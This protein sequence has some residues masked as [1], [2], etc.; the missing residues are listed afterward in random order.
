MS[1]VLRRNYPQISLYKNG[2]KK[3]LRVHS[4][5]ALCFL[6]YVKTDRKTVIDHIDNNPLNNNIDNVTH[7]G[8]VRIINEKYKD[9][10][11]N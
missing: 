6:D 2:L 1:G 11:R 10:R 7:V 8:L 3:T 5:M 4:L 9:G